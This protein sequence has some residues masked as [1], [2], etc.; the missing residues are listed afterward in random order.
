MSSQLSS[1]EVFRLVFKEIKFP[2]FAIDPKVLAEVIESNLGKEIGTSIHM[3]LESYSDKREFLIKSIMGTIQ[4][5][6]FPESFLKI[7]ERSPF[8]KPLLTKQS[9]KKLVEA[10]MPLSS[11]TGNNVL[12]WQEQTYWPAAYNILFHQ[13]LSLCYLFKYALNKRKEEIMKTG[14]DSEIL[15]EYP[16]MMPTTIHYAFASLG[17]W[18]G[19]AVNM[20]YFSNYATDPQIRENNINVGYLQRIG[21]DPIVAKEMSDSGMVGLPASILMPLMTAQG[22]GIY[23]GSLP[24]DEW[25]IVNLPQNKLLE[26]SAKDVFEKEKLAGFIMDKYYRTPFRA[27]NPNNQGLLGANTV[28]RDHYTDFYKRIG[29][30]PLVRC[31]H[32][33]APIIEVSSLKQIQEY[34]HEIPI[35]DKEGVFFRGQTSMYTL[36]RTDGIKKLLF[37]NSCSMEPSLVTAAART[38]FDYDQIHFALKYFLRENLEYN[39]DYKYPDGY[40][41]F[42][43]KQK[44]AMLETD[45]AIMALAQ[46]YGIPSHGLDV[47]TNAEVALWFATNKY[48]VNSQGVASYSNLN[49]SDWNLDNSKWPVIFVCQTVTNTIR[50]SLHN[51]LELSD[52]GI[53]ALRPIRQ[54]AK[55]FLGGH[56]EHQNRL[57]E[58]VVCIFRLKP[59]NYISPTDF[60][61]LFPPPEDDKAYRLLLDFSANTYFHSMGSKKVNRFH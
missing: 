41:I 8:L 10:E 57:A 14:S 39:M 47:T 9:L 28:M 31:K 46:H 38:K 12:T 48:E 56:G 13:L 33:C 23:F 11:I 34:V 1:E 26:E 7:L 15:G 43:E 20:Q 55:F 50:P 16:R 3:G 61:F 25:N 35:R 21:Y 49:I 40:K 32:Y 59:E 51:C 52:C 19:G 53:T 5:I 22:N 37:S 17:A 58:C 42:Q 18:L 44:S 30:T 29:K 4:G 24:V 60:N 6:K 45:Y 54:N 36:P 27:R 2:F